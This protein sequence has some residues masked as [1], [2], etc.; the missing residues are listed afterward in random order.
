MSR[1]KT[2]ILPLRTIKINIPQKKLCKLFYQHN[3]LSD[4]DTLILGQKLSEIERVQNCLSHARSVVEKVLMRAGGF[5][6]R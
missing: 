5:G 2:D 4:E 6:N 1:E 3:F